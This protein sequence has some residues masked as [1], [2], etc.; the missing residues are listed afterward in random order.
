MW[1]CHDQIC[2]EISLA[3]L[4]RTFR[5]TE[6]GFQG[7]ARC[8]SGENLWTWC[9]GT[10]VPSTRADHTLSWPWC[11]PVALRNAAAFQIETNAVFG[12]VVYPGTILEFHLPFSRP[13]L[14]VFNLESLGIAAITCSINEVEM[15]HVGQVLYLIKKKTHVN[16]KREVYHYIFCFIWNM[17]Q[18]CFTFKV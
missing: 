9:W 6:K 11:W 15:L 16:I 3:T 14:F 13:C 5:G 17:E 18:K 2:F 7:A 1:K 4:W 8:P 12:H 10:V